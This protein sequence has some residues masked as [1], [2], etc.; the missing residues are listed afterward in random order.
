MTS[1]LEYDW[2]ILED[3]QQLVTEQPLYLDLILLLLL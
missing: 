3:D 2:S 1:I